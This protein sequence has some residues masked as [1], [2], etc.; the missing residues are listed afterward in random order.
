MSDVNRT[1]SV[2]APDAVP[3]QADQLKE[4]LA[5]NERLRK[6]EVLAVKLMNS[7]NC[8]ADCACD[9]I[10]WEMKQVLDGR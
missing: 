3:S 5:E 1:P 10:A 6:L 7:Q 4:L 2:H 9:T 8:L